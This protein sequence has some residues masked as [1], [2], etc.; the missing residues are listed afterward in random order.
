[1]LGHQSSLVTA[2]SLASEYARFVVQL[3]KDLVPVVYDGWTVSVAGIEVPLSHMTAE[4][5]HALAVRSP[6]PEYS[7]SSIET[8]TAYQRS[9][10][11]SLADVM[12]V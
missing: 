4:Q 8:I 1:M 2:T 7:R 9:S 12:K 11:L 5:F 6:E 3:T 10:H